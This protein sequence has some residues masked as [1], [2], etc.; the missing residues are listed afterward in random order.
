MT[1]ELVLFVIVV[2]LT[3]FNNG[4][5]AYIHFE[6]YPLL[7]RVGKS[8]FAG[9]LGD[10]EARLTIPLMLPYGLTV[11]SNLALLVIRP[12]PV[13]LVGVIVALVLNI[14]VAV[15]TITLATPVYN[16]IKQAQQAGGADMDSLMN[17]NLLR[18]L[19]SSAASL[20]LLYLL[21]T[22]LAV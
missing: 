11:L 17:I 19:L 21:L 3:L 4:V 1:I 5:Q 15:V 7:R 8:E 14:A 12:E 9:Y 20:T 18:L 16:R 13:P 10:Y 6:A 22:L 2:A